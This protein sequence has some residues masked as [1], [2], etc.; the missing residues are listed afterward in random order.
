M[1][2]RIPYIM[3]I[4]YMKENIVLLLLQRMVRQRKKLIYVIEALPS[5]Q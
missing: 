2:I 4:Q 3:R 1:N 5:D